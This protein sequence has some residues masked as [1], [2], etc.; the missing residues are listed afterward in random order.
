MNENMETRPYNP[1]PQEEPA[2]SPEV[3]DYG[4]GRYA[5]YESV[6]PSESPDEEVASVDIVSGEKKITMSAPVKEFEEFKES[7][8]NMMFAFARFIEAAGM[9]I[10]KD[11]TKEQVNLLAA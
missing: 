1:D 8:K 10:G 2:P 4:E 6:Q 11:E 5:S 3:T 7:F 9:E